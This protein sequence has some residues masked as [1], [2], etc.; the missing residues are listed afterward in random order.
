[1]IFSINLY[2]TIL[3]NICI[4][5][6]NNQLELYTNQ[7]IDKQRPIGRLN[8]RKKRIFHIDKSKPFTKL[9]RKK[10]KKY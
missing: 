10:E 9:A 5:L 6:L 2:F 1:M 8:K 4:I 7:Q 3:D